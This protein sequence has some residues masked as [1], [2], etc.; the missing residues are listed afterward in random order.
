VV[1]GGNQKGTDTKGAWMLK[2]SRISRVVYYDCIRARGSFR[3]F[4]AINRPHLAPIADNTY[5]GSPRGAVTIPSRVLHACRQLQ[6]ST[7]RERA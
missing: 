5:P 4:N 3:Q 1:T 2:I 6:R 7:G